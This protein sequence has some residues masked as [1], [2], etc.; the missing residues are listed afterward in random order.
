MKPARLALFLFLL[1]PALALADTVSVHNLRLW[2]APDHTRLVFD[3]SG[4]LEHRLTSLRDPERLVI[5]MDDAR[6]SDGLAPLD[7]GRSHIAAVRAAEPA[8]GKLR[9]TLDLR[10][11]VRPNGFVL[12]PFGQYGHRLVIDLYDEAAVEVEPEPVPRAAPPA[13]PA[14]RPRDLVVAI[15]AGHGGEDPGAIGRLYRTREKD[16]TLAIARELAKLVDAT[17][18]M[19]AV[20]IR[21]GDYYVG[22]RERTRKA[23]RHNADVF[24]SIHADSLPGRRASRAR[25]SS[26][27]AL[28]DRGATN[29]LARALADSENSSDWIGGIGA[30]E[31]DNDVRRLLG[32]LV[33]TATIGDSLELGTDMLGS[34]RTVGPL[35]SSKVA[36]AGFMV[37]KSPTPSVL[38]ETAFISNPQEER[39]LRDPRHQRRIAEG[40]HRGLKRAAPRLIARRDD[41]GQG[42]QAATPPPAVPAAPAAQA[43]PLVAGMR[44]HVVK[45]GET[46]SAISRLYDIHVDALRFLNE[47][48]GNDLT[49]GMKLRIPARA[50]DS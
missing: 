26:V 30:R 20:L 25:G 9:I 14:L 29:E 7:V 48:Q 45:P 11:P 8:D 15:D 12:K 49:V 47:L 27:Y 42:L 31:V 10:R 19:K 3:L 18:G 33:K 44:E 35:H 4:P 6:L 16:V 40:I 24:V 22:L 41:G 5:E 17:P 34:L 37:L 46:L 38:V 23:D 39:M 32:D 36:Q 43:A 2:Q 13:R 50:G 21:N 1:I 28:S